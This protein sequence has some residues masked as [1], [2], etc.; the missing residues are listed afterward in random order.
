MYR[1]IERTIDRKYCSIRNKLIMN[2]PIIS[3]VNLILYDY[4]LCYN[5]LC[6]NSR[7]YV[8]NNSCT[9]STIITIVILTI[10]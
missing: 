7:Y 9:I 5:F 2:N 6:T 3:Y 4:Y 8:I 1:K 10:P